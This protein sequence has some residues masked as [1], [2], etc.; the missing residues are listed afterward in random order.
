MGAGQKGVS[1]NLEMSV[2]ETKVGMKVG[3]VG[4][5]NRDVERTRVWV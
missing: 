2:A 3:G 1:T 4:R 5:D